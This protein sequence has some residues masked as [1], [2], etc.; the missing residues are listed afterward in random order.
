M[1]DDAY[2]ILVDFASEGSCN[3][4][5]AEITYS[6]NVDFSHNP[7]ALS[8]YHTEKVEDELRP[9]GPYASKQIG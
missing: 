6:A 5:P 1:P 4:C 3:P 9:A 7:S 8:V 2:K